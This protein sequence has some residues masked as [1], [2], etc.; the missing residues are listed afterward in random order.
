MVGFNSSSS[1]KAA[2]TSKRLN[3]SSG[4]EFQFKQQ[5]E[6][7]CYLIFVNF[8][9]ACTRV[10]IQAAARK[11]LLPRIYRGSFSAQ[12]SMVS[13]QAAARKP[14]LRD[15]ELGIL[16]VLR[17]FNSSSSPKAA[18]TC[19]HSNPLNLP[20]VC[21]NSSSSPKAAATV[22]LYRKSKSDLVSIQ[23]AARKPLLPRGS[24][25]YEKCSGFNSSS[26]PKAAATYLSRV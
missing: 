15:W 18:A 12:I 14:L 16:E 26:S 13:I 10:S 19:R 2:A 17:G 1:P 6:S 22:N 8:S 3:P 23:A 21:F 24:Y 25:E 20:N 9:L 7:R 5:P 11:P 4:I